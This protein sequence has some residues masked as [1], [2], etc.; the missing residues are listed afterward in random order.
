MGFKIMQEHIADNKVIYEE[1]IAIALTKSDA[2]FIV[3]NLRKA[4]NN[5][6]FYYKENK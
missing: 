3:E 5:Q 4:N 2:K 6:C 1:L